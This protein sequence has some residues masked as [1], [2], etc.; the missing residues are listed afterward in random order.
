MKEINKNMGFYHPEK[1]FLVAGS[2]DS[3]YEL[4]AFDQALINAGIADVNLSTI[5]SIIPPHCQRID[6][7][8]LVAGGIEHVVQNVGCTFAGVVEL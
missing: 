4:V 1:Y 8:P 6:P 7:I 5:S 3:K 2:G